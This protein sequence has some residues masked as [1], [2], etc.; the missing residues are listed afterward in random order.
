[1]HTQHYPFEVPV[2]S[3]NWMNM[4]EFVFGWARIIFLETL[5]N[6][7]WWCRCCLTI[8]F[9]R[10]SDTETQLFS[11]LGWYRHTSSSRQFRNILCWLEILN[12]C[13]DGGNGN[14]YCSSSKNSSPNTNDLYIHYM[15]KSTG[16]PFFRRE[17][18]RHCH[19]RIEKSSVQT[20]AIRSTHFPRISLYALTFVL[21]EI[22]KVVKPFI[23]RGCP[24]TFGNIVYLF[25]C[26][27]RN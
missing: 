15:D 7:M 1:M 21:M 12:Y 4:L 26:A 19:V 16:T 6:N 2:V 25:W 8:L 23:R 3:D 17:K 22:T 9:L 20:V 24:N 27:I 14:Y 5:P 10:F 13:P 11:A 18:K